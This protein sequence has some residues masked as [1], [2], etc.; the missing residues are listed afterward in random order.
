MSSVKINEKKLVEELKA[1]VFS[2]INKKISQQNLIDKCIKY[3]YENLDDFIQKEL[4][5]PKL[6]EEKIKK[7]L[8]NTIKSG[9]HFPDKSDD[10]LIYGL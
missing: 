6:T 9:Y 10:E 8:D 4:Q 1:K 7:I 2:L 5:I 3:S